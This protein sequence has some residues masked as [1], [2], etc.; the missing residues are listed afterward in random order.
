MVPVVPLIYFGLGEMDE[1]AVVRTTPKKNQ[2]GECCWTVN[3]KKELVEEGK[4]IK[5]IEAT[6]LLIYCEDCAGIRD[7]HKMVVPLKTPRPG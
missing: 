3:V 4:T 6:G 2:R 1:L 5:V 7:F